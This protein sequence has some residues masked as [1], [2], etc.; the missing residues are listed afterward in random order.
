MRYCKT[1]NAYIAEPFDKCP[2]CQNEIINKEILSEEFYIF[3][4]SDSRRKKSKLFKFLL[5]F[6]I[7]AAVITLCLD[8]LIGL[9]GQINWSVLVVIWCAFA[10]VA[11]LP[12][13]VRVR[14]FGDIVWNI[15]FWGIVGSILTTWYLDSFDALMGIILPIILIVL[16]VIE[17]IV[18]L[19]EK[20]AGSMI[21]YMTVVLGTLLFIIIRSLCGFEITIMLNITISVAAVLTI[22]LVAIKSERVFGDLRKKL[23]L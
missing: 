19:A 9:H 2:L 20:N 12:L 17:F 13:F 5:Y 14:P 21:F 7:L 1:C 16:L 3:P 10:I 22:L 15:G 23:S 11:I 6:T 18:V 4:D 8:L